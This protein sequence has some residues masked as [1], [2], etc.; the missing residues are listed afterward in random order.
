MDVQVV[1]DV[2]LARLFLCCLDYVRSGSHSVK[3]VTCVSSPKLVL[4]NSRR[5]VFFLASLAKKAAALGFP[6]MCLGE[7]N[8]AARADAFGVGEPV[9]F[10]DE[11]FF[12]GHEIEAVL[13]RLLNQGA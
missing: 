1:P 3:R 4:T 8:V 6:Q 2:A 9:L 11:G 7:W 13:P 12:P 5:F 10:Q